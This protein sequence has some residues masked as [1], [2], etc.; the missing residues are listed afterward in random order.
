MIV[1]FIF[2]SGTVLFM[3]VLFVAVID[4]VLFRFFWDW[5]FF[6]IPN[7]KVCFIVLSDSVLFMALEIAFFSVSVINV[8]LDLSVRGFFLLL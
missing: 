8:F 5:I 1:F 3:V 2:L 6:K 4:R 7:K